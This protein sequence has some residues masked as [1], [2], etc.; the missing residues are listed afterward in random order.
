MLEADH[1]L[2]LA[3]SEDMKPCKQQRL[4]NSNDRTEAQYAGCRVAQSAR[5]PISPSLYSARTRFALLVALMW[6]QYVGS[7]GVY[8]GLMLGR[9]HKGREA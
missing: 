3:R 2:N 6:S 5:P 4:Q 9:L 7:R 8:L 1:R